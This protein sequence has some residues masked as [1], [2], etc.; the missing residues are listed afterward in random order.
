MSTRDSQ[1]GTPRASVTVTHLDR[2][3]SADARDR[4]L[5]S[6]TMRIGAVALAVILAT[7][8][9]LTVTRLAL[10]AGPHW[11]TPATTLDAHAVTA[12]GQGT[13]RG[14]PGSSRLALLGPLPVLD[15]RSTNAL[16]PGALVILP[17]PDLPPHSS[18]VL[19]EVS[20]VDATGPGAVTLESSAGQVTALQ[21]A[22]AKGQTSTVTVAALG[23]D[24]ALRLRT[25]GGGHVLVN[26]IGAFEPS[27]ASTS[28]RMVAVPPSQ[29]LLLTPKTGGKNAVID[30]STVESLRNAGTFAAVVV[31]ITADVGPNG[32]F[33]A[34]GPSA[35]KLTQVVYWTATTGDDRIRDG[36]VILPVAGGSV[37]L[38]YEAG[39]QLAADVIGYVTD[40]TAPSAT[41]GLVVPVPPTA[42]GPVTV[43]PGRPAD[44]TL[45]GLGD[46]P[47]SHV[48]GALLAVTA[49]GDIAGAVTV[50]TPGTE[51]PQVATLHAAK[52]PG[53]PT[54][55]LVTAVDGKV[56]VASET[57]AT[58]ALTAQILI[59]GD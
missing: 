4:T 58:V 56:A 2:P 32:G 48:D 24:G 1:D 7:A 49:T 42:S 27:V 47:A 37:H 10:G 22:K 59:L 20:M 57:P 16:A 34:L 12:N 55:T 50:Y 54:P 8:G 25:E 23:A 33:V 36:L 46:I 43:A 5:R 39:S 26:L 13:G 31:H 45:A 14:V 18:A 30:L 3:G 29:A 11:T 21:L 40:G 28:G 44:L 38:H 9:T 17:L 6:P 19:L 52:S 35:D 53:R 15:T 51:P 41:V